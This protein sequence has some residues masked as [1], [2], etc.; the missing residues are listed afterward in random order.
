MGS[1]DIAQMAGTPRALPHRRFNWEFG[2]KLS[3]KKKRWAKTNRVAKVGRIVQL[4][5]LRGERE[6]DVQE[7]GRSRQSRAGGSEV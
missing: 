6:N 4:A 5:W 2:E 7:A 3:V 1:D